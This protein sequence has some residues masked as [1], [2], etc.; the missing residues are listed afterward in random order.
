MVTCLHTVAETARFL[1]DAEAA[2]LAADEVRAMV[3]AVAA[4]P[5]GGDE[6]KGSGGVRKVRFA[7]RGK[8][9]SGGYRVMVAYLGED[10]PAYL[11]ALLS[12]GDRGNFTDREVAAMKAVT[13]A[14]K[15]GWRE[16]KG[17]A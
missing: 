2:G 15:Q 12:K 4:D 14:I 13:A 16:R 3:D 11:V 7:G 5:L 9:K 1:K 6:V 10:V 8:G 17:G